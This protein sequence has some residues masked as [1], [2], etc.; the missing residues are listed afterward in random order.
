MSSIIWTRAMDDWEYDKKILSDLDLEVLHFPCIE[1]TPVPVRFPKQKPQIFIFTSAN[2]VRYSQRH[3]ALIN[4]VRSSE[5]VYAIG[6]STQAALNAAK[7]HAEIPSEIQTAEQMSIWISRN[8]APHTSVAIPSA[9]EPAFD[10]KGYLERYAIHV[11]VL[12]VYQTHRT[13]R[14]PNGKVPDAATVERQ[15]QSLEGVVCFASPSAVEGFVYTL[16]PQ[17]NRLADE[18]AAIVIGATT[19]KAAEAHF[20]RVILSEEQSIV[21]L[22]QKA[23]TEF[24]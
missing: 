7:I 12:P 18:L 3:P 2:A 24:R 11:D 5:G 1:L 6:P 16:T 8:I 4:L 21:S 9:K 20:K 10:F 19:K 22:A 23:Q 14:L 15:I 13:L 17:L